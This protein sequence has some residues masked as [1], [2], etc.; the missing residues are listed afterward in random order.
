MKKILIKSGK[1]IDGVSNQ[2]ILTDILCEDGKV[3]KIE[4]NIEGSGAEVIDASGKYVLP[5]L[6]DV[7]VH[8]RDPGFEYKEDIYTGAKA[9]ARGGFTS[10]VLM[11]N[12]KP[13]VDNEE[14]LSYI[15]NKGAETAINV[16]TCA[17]VTMGMEGQKM[18]DMDSLYHKGAVGFTDDGKPVM[19]AELVRNA[20]IKVKEL[21]VPISFH[22]ENPEF[23]TNNGVNRGA[24][25]EHYGIGGSPREAEID[26]I[27]R[28]I[29]IAKETGAD[30]NVQHIS[31]KEGV[32]IVRNAR[33]THKNIHAEATPHH[34]SLDE[35]AVIE[36]GTNAKM[37]PPLRTSDDRMAIIEGL[38]DGTIDLIATDHAPHSSEEKAQDIT[39]APSGIIGLETAL[40]LGIT[41]LVCPGY[42]SMNQLVEKMSTNPAKLYKLEAG[43]I[44]AGGKADM[45]IV[46]DKADMVYTSYE[47]KSS[48]TPFTGVQLKGKVMYTICNGLVVYKA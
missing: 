5:G 46:D 47:S 11:A 12:T 15:L 23:I 45:I 30:I 3:V 14:T 2:E 36:H 18:V 19:D 22:E 27:A 34:F 25:S 4:E 31:S 13:T 9:A 48:N 16:Y 8:F 32:E 40:S 1:L 24:A 21:G 6:V 17:T 42:L 39:K 35:Q 29:E 28:D 37:N 41:N 38:R 10:V 7:H 44:E 33:K 20:M 43:T 26:L